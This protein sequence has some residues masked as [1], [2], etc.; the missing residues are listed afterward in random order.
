MGQTPMVSPVPLR[1]PQL[2]KLVVFFQIL[3]LGK[4][5]LAFFFLNLRKG[6]SPSEKG[7]IVVSQLRLPAVW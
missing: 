3:P 1:L 4:I 2:C 7:G 6:G 5:M